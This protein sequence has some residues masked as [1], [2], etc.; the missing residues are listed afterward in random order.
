MAQSNREMPVRADGWRPA[1]EV[2]EGII[3][4]FVGEAEAGAAR[5]GTRE[6]M[7]G[8]VILVVLGILIMGGVGSA[9]AA[10]MVPV[11]LFLAG[12]VYMI[13]KARPVPVQ[14]EK[15]LA[16]IGGPGQLPAGYLVH[17]GAW[18]AG[19]AEHVAYL[20][21][22]QLQ[23]ASELARHFPGSVD[24]LLIFTG[25]VAAHF[26]LARNASAD[27]VRKRARDL[28]QVGLPILRDY[29]EKYP[30]AP[31]RPAGGKGKK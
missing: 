21:E 3:D 30:P 27:D 26:P 15:T 31:P 12:A 13:S 8:A 14:R 18:A 16:R 5:D 25:S 19:M 4:R 7:A 9:A 22:S 17:P 29:H 1:D 28:V 24:D 10:I 2:F 20:P 11:G 23:A 6:F